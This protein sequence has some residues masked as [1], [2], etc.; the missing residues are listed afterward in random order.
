MAVSGRRLHGIRVQFKTR[1]GEVNMMVGM[2]ERFERI[3]KRALAALLKRGM[4]QEGESIALAFDG[5][6][7]DD[8]E[9]PASLDLE[10]KFAVDVRVLAC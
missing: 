7:I 6:K 9:T 4:V 2:N 10:D 8:D 1:T 5:D 3:G